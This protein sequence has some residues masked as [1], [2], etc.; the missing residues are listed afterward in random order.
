MTRSAKLI[1]SYTLREGNRRI[2][3]ASR[4]L[5]LAREAVVE[6]HLR[7]NAFVKQGIV[8]EHLRKAECVQHTILQALEAS[9]HSAMGETLW[10]VDACGG[11]SLRCSSNCSRRQALFDQ[12][13]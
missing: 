5:S 7:L 9:V 3:N 2:H 8:P 4:V 6:A 11:Q 10:L 12:K 1:E 13:E